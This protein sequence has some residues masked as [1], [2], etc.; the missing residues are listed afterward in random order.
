MTG[1]L[2][3]DDISITQNGKYVKNFFTA[4]SG[5]DA[6]CE[7]NAMKMIKT[8]FC[9]NVNG[10]SSYIVYITKDAK[11]AG[12]IHD[13]A[14]TQREM[15]GDNQWYYNVSTVK[16]C[17]DCR[18]PEFFHDCDYYATVIEHNNGDWDKTPTYKLYIAE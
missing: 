14:V 15:L 1:T 7:V 2:P 9:K 11:T 10:S 13:V 4:L 18:I 12:N 5:Y 6:K 17:K 3:D 8:S 16:V